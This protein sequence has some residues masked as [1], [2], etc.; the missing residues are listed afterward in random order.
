M[1]HVTIKES[2]ST[3]KIT[4][5]MKSNTWAE[6]IQHGNLY[7]VYKSP[8]GEYY[9]VTK[10]NGMIYRLPNGDP[11]LDVIPIEDSEIIFHV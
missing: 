1:S 4:T 7:L 2:P 11:R 6:I 3:H 9:Q 8:N 5:T 10:A